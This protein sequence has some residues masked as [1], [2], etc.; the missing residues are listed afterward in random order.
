[1][2]SPWGVLNYR[3]LIDVLYAVTVILTDTPL[4]GREKRPLPRTRQCHRQGRDTA[5]AKDEK[6][7]SPTRWIFKLFQKQRWTV[8]REYGL[9][10]AQRY[11]L[12]L[13]R[14]DLHWELTLCFSEICFSDDFSLFDMRR[15]P[16]SINRSFV[17]SFVL[18][19][20]HLSQTR[21]RYNK[22]W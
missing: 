4:K 13:N 18:Q 20:K 6:G 10:W 9:F 17:R 15:R 3:F 12:E 19:W 11:H 7:L 2:Q 5:I 21:N 1:M 22:R 8:W 16:S 14:P